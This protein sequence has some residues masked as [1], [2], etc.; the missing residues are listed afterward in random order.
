MS[1]DEL[2][3]HSLI[4][5]RNVSSD[6]MVIQASSTTST[7]EAAGQPSFANDEPCT[8]QPESNE[9]HLSSNEDHPIV[10]LEDQCPKQEISLSASNHEV[11]RALLQRKQ[12]LMELVSSEEGYVRRLKLV[13]DFYIPAVSAPSTAPSGVDNNP[14]GTVGSITHSDSQNPPPVAPEDLAARWRIVWGNWIQ[15]YEWHSAFLEKLVSLV[16]SDPDRIPKLFIDSRA[17]LRSIY[18]KYCE[19]HRKA[20]LIAEQYQDF[21]E[22]LRIYIGDKEDVVSHLMQPVQRIMRYQLPIAEILKY[23]QRACSPD[24]MLWKKT[25]EI[26]KEIPKDTQLILEVS[27]VFLV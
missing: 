26:M 21:F 14:S 1:A 9:E 27:E 11:T 12:P 19:N 17:R 24:L 10:K 6:M 16:D 20:A 8:V 15:L 22:E 3:S 7:E 23:T 25:L 2:G 13:K 5:S 4:E 18:S